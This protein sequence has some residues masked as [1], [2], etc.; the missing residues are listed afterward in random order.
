MFSFTFELQECWP[1]E[2]DDQAK[3]RTSPLPPNSQ[4]MLSLQCQTPVAMYSAY[5]M[6]LVYLTQCDLCGGKSFHEYKQP[7]GSYLVC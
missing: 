1:F 4:K 3:D 7:W 2:A 5:L 6:T